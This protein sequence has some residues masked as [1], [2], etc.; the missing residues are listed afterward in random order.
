RHLDTM[1]RKRST[2]EA[3]ESIL[4]VHL[5]PFF[6]GRSLE[7]VSRY[8]VEALMAAKRREG[9]SAKSILNF[10]SFLHSVFAHAEKRGWASSNPVK[11]IEKPRVETQDPDIRFLHSEEVEALFRS[12]PDGTLGDTDRA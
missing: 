11:A 1:G 6:A 5:A 4:R 2:T 10:V 3:Y 12:V 8:D 7:Q 9:K